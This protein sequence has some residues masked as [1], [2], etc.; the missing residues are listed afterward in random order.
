MIAAG[1]DGNL[2]FTQPNGMLGRL[3][4]SG[5]VYQLPAVLSARTAS[6]TRPERLLI[7]AP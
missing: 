3:S 6:P 4:P 5:I 1:R 7:S 2:W